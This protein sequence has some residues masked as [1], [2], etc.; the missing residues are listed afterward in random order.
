MN[1]LGG[2]IPPELGSLTNLM[3]LYLYSND[4]V[5]EIP[6]ELG[7][8]AHLQRLNIYGNNLEGCIP[9]GLRRFDIVGSESSNPN[10]R[11]CEED[12]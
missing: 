12:Q 10:L 11:R 4:L 7:Q 5:G 9:E 3:D 8:L 2:E 6:E 1:P